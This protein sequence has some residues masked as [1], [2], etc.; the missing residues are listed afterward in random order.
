ML[1]KPPRSSLE[2]NISRVL[3][4]FLDLI[5]TVITI[6]TTVITIVIVH[7]DIIRTCQLFAIR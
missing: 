5:T 7:F 1:Q 2:I 4:G 3:I 6:V